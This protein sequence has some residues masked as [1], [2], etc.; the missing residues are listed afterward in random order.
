MKHNRE[1]CRWALSFAVIAAMALPI[2][3]SWAREMSPDQGAKA[4]NK[5]AEGK[6]KPGKAEDKK[7]EAEDKKAAAKAKGQAAEHQG[8]AEGAKT[9]GVGAGA[10][11]A[12]DPADK[13]ERIKQRATQ[14]AQQRGARAKMLRKKAK[15]QAKAA[16]RG[17]PMEKAL[18]QEL[19]RHA[20]RMAR[21]HRIEALAAETG[22][23]DA[24][25]RVETLMQKEMRRHN[26]WISLYSKGSDPA[27]IDNAVESTMGNAPKA[28]EAAANQPAAGEDG[29]EAKKDTTDAE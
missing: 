25:T 7:A 19:L 14:R 11:G 27:T 15:M 9:G 18:K 23:G 28:S 1:I 10:A 6:G 22:N 12:G 26:R 5:K 2:S 16:L 13:L 21:L 29:D 4:E 17:K 8:K 24:V 3:D 20:R